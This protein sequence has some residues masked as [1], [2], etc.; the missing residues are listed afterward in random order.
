MTVS[1]H[2]RDRVL[3]TL[4]TLDTLDGLD[5]LGTLDHGTR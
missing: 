3:D 4:Y 5:L 2:D 1:T